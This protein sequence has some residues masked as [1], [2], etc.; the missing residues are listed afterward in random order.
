MKETATTDGASVIYAGVAKTFP[1]SL[2][3]GKEKNIIK[4]LPKKPKGTKKDN[5]LLRTIFSPKPL[6][7]SFAMAVG[8]PVEEN[9]KSMQ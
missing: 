9:V 6:E 7:I 1:C 5:A 2:A 8:T 4:R 3:I